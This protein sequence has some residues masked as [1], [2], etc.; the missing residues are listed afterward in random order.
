MGITAIL[1]RSRRSDQAGARER[2]ESPAVVQKGRAVRHPTGGGI[3]IARTTES[4]T[5]NDHI[6]CNLLDYN[7]DEITSGP[8]ANVEVY[9]FIMNGTALND[10]V[11][12]LEVSKDIPV[13]KIGDTWYCTAV[14]QGNEE[15]DCYEAS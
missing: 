10:A 7:G 8:E 3:R 12:R 13:S 11:P 1:D 9:C 4:A 6:T 15:C 2:P 5:G 14:F